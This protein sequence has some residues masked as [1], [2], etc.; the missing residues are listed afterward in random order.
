MPVFAAARPELVGL[1][2]ARFVV[3]VP[4]P[5]GRLELAVIVLV[6]AV[7]VA[8]LA[9]T[10]V[11]FPLLIYQGDFSVGSCLPDRCWI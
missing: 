8:I 2:A 7:E 5:S 10:I 3:A 6:V 4:E 1:V 11:K 9:G